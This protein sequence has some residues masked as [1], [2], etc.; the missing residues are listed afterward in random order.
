MRAKSFQS[1]P[2]S[3]FT[4]YVT[5]MAVAQGLFPGPHICREHKGKNP[6]EKNGWKSLPLASLLMTFPGILGPLACQCSPR[7]WEQIS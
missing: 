7:F 4:L 5:P 1:S 2:S 6:L 3:P